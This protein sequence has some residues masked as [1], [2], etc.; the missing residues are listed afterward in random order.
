MASTSPV[1]VMAPQSLSAMTVVPLPH[2]AL[3]ISPRTA[4]MSKSGCPFA[5]I[6]SPSS[7]PGSRVPVED[8]STR[9]DPASAENP[10]VDDLTAD[11]SNESTPRRRRCPRWARLL[12]FAAKSC[13][14][15]V[16]MRS[17]KP[18][19]MNACRAVHKALSGTRTGTQ[20]LIKEMPEAGS[21][22]KNI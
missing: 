14:K 10:A 15:H 9:A 18:V 7:A 11:P 19:I 2:F 20:A 21:H 12:R 16:I 13:A 5:G 1:P 17:L 3:S 6:L 8:V 4:R 22:L